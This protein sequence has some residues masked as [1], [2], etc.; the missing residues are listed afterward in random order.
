MIKCRIKEKNH[1]LSGLVIISET[2][3]CYIGEL[4]T[5]MVKL[6]AS[7]HTISVDT[8]IQITVF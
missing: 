4:I 1:R 5:L 6:F 7:N 3:F 8:G 2:L